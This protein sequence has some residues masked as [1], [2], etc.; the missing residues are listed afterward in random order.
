MDVSSSLTDTVWSHVGKTYTCTSCYVCGNFKETYKLTEKGLEGDS[1]Q[2][3]IDHL[4]YGLFRISL[5][6][7][8]P[9]FYKVLYTNNEK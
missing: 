3:N 2:I 4:Y 7:L 8:M 5:I 1:S 9:C 6:Y